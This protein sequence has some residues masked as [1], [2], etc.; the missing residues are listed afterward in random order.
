MRVRKLVFITTVEPRYNETN[1][2]SQSLALRYIGVLFHTF[3]YYW[4]GEYRL[5]SGLV[6]YTG[7]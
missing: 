2:A 3:Y 1:T 6:C 4:G 5:L 7:S